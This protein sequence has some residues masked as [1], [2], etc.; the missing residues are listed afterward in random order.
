[1]TQ[2]LIPALIFA[3]LGI[4]AGL[5]LSIFSK[6]FAVKVDERVE[7]IRDALPGANCGACGF[8]G[9]DGYAARLVEDD[10][11]KTNLCLPGGAEAAKVISE[12]LGK[13]FE[14]V[15]PMVAEVY[16]KGTSETTG[17]I[18]EYD[19][20][21]SC[22]AC[23]L[24]YSGKGKCNYGC[25]GFGDCQKVCQYGA[26]SIVDGRA[27]VNE[28]LCVGC[29]MCA[30]V[31]PK[32]IIGVHKKAQKV[33]VKC[34]NCDLGKYTRSACSAGCIGCKKCEKTCRYDAIHVERNKARIDY[35]KCTNCGEC[36][37]A[38]P[39]QCILV[40]E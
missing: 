27:H 17:D 37:A 7:K 30:G 4:F 14:A 22:S 31:C 20:I 9:C 34:F 16:C 18:F 13:N 6:V 39:V 12:V 5:L 28:E 26:I 2:I 15:E 35:D 21:Y 38:C 19:G 25:L 8:S 24:Y 36:A 23:N 10:S 11:V 33:V 29:G 40:K 32:G 3:G 1:M